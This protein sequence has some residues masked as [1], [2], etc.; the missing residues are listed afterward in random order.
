MA[1]L[2]ESAGTAPTAR[3]LRGFQITIHRLGNPKARTIME[4]NHER[5]M[6]VDMDGYGARPQ[7]RQGSENPRSTPGNTSKRSLIVVANRLP[8]QQSSGRGMDGPK[9][10]SASGGLVTALVPTL[11]ATR[12]VWVGWNGS[13]EQKVASFVHDGVAIRPVTLSESD[14]N[15]FYNHMSNRTLWP[16]YHDAIR[17]PEFDR[18]HW[19]PYVEVNRRYARAA[20]R[21][22]NPG[23]VVWVH[24]YHLQLVPAM[25]RQIR[26]D[27]RIGF[28]LHIPFPPEEIFAWL[29]WRREIL[30]GLLGAD[31][32][33]FQTH[34]AVR[35]FSRLARR[36]TSTDGTDISLRY[37]E[38]TV[39]V[40]SWPISIDADW[41][42]KI[43]SDR[44]TTIPEAAQIRARLGSGRKIL[45]CVDR[46]DY[47]KGIDARL[48]AYQLL[49]Q[50]GKVTVNDAVLVQIAV[51]SRE[52]VA[53]YAHMRTQI[54]RL[55]GRINGE[56]SEPGR[57]A[58][59]YFRRNYTREELVAFYRAADV[60]VVTPLRDGMNLVAKEYVATRYDLSGT[61]IL[62]EFAGA[63][64]ELRRAILVN[65]RDI[66]G[67]AE[68]MHKAITM[69]PGESRHLMGILRSQVRRHDVYEWADNFLEALGE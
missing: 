31:V 66:E 49:L 4:T 62:S 26:P 41:F 64:E 36:F 2:A 7:G 20:A 24:D 9:W 60:M 30:E 38:R 67:V 3:P 33:G 44:R 52:R 28:F 65:P 16:L 22:A 34:S 21:A 25:V 18:K 29:P 50:S 1:T 17:T 10:Q 47:T 19:R 42:E 15:G 12:G 59:H 69:P 14:I 27:V 40:G 56:Y 57:V 13:S 37:D 54:E 51:P 6:V 61:L 46:L 63:A 11:K 58:V 35:N 48:Q 68:A 5:G 53:D 23:D 43:A 39:R 32:V 45:L 8:V 55:V